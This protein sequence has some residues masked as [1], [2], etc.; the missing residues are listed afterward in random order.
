MLRIMSPED[1]LIDDADLVWYKRRQ[2]LQHKNAYNFYITTDFATSEKEAAD[3]SPINVWGLTNNGDWLWVDGVCKK[4]LMNK[5]IDDLFRLVQEW[6]PQEVGIEVNGQ[7]AGFISWIQNEMGYRNNYFTLSTGKNSKQIGIRSNKD[8]MSRFLL[9]AVPLFKAKKIWLPEEL[10]DSD[11]L[12]ELLSEIS[13]ATVK[14]FKSKHDDQLDTISMLHELNSWR[15][16]DSAPY[17]E[18]EDARGGS[19]MWKDEEVV[20]ATSSYFV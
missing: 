14:G 4:Q 3:Y 15:P 20:P 2:V 12:T 16:S 5:S 8:K 18:E 10:K 17:E 13:L 11:E 9:N 1:R 19:K 6:R 7:Q